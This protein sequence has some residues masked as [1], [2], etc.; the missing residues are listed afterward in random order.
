MQPI[1]GTERTIPCDTLLLSIGLIPENELSTR[2]GVELS[3]VTNGPVVDN[4]LSTNLPGIFACGNVLHVHDLVDNVTAEALNAGA[5]A[6]V[7]AKGSRVHTGTAL[8][9]KPQAPVRYTVPSLIYPED[10]EDV[11]IK[12]R[13][14]APTDNSHVLVKSGDTIVYEGKKNRNL[15]PSIMEEVKIKKEQLSGLTEPLVVSVLS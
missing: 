5:N 14:A 10:Q 7:Y 3:R 8:D 11:T 1:P 9:V 15:I 4:T 12:F 2:A 13:V 6:A